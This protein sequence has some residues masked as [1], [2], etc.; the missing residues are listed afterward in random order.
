MIAYLC[1]GFGIFLLFGFKI[2]L[3][4]LFAGGVDGVLVTVDVVVV[5]GL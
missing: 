5:V 2:S 3:M 4:I 1:T